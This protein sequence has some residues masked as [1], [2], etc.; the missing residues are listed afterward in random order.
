METRL[1]DPEQK[2]YDLGFELA[3]LLEQTEL[4]ICDV[5]RCNSLH[6]S[7]EEIGRE[8]LD[9]VVMLNLLGCKLLLSWVAE[10]LAGACHSRHDA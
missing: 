6:R 9:S 7:L 3:A 2:L 5:R 4:G 8:I 10:S 1:E